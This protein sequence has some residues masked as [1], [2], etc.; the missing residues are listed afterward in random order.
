MTMT[1][2]QPDIVSS[3]PAP[4]NVGSIAM[5]TSDASKT[6]FMQEISNED[7]DLAEQEQNK[8]PETPFEE[9]VESRE[10]I[11]EKICAIKCRMV[12]F[13]VRQWDIQ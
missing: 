13:S 5:L 3:A 10:I 2:D 8:S 4:V 9:V 1:P 11:Q 12:D 7:L 6:Q